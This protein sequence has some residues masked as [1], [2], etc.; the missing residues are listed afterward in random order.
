MTL[1]SNPYCC[2]INNCPKNHFKKSEKPKTLTV[3]KLDQECLYSNCIYYHPNRSIESC[4]LDCCNWYCKKL[5]RSFRPIYRRP[6]NN[7]FVTD[8]SLIENICS[9]L[10]FA[11]IHNL[12]QTCS[13]LPTLFPQNSKSWIERLNIQKQMYI[14]AKLFSNFYYWNPVEITS[15]E[16]QTTRLLVCSGHFHHSFYSP[17]DFLNNLV[18]IE[19]NVYPRWMTETI[20]LTK[21]SLGYREPY[22]KEGYCHAIDEFG[23]W[24]EAKI[25]NDVIQLRI[26][27]IIVSIPLK[28]NEARLACPSLHYIKNWKNQLQRSDKLYIVM[29]EIKYNAKIFDIREDRF[30]LLVDKCGICE[31][32]IVNKDSPLIKPYHI[33]YPNF[34]TDHYVLNPRYF[35]NSSKKTT[36]TKEVI[37]TIDKNSGNHSIEFVN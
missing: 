4:L 18:P 14:K 23:Y 5:H 22:T 16:L 26:G 27:K 25:E 21:Y 29:N 8:S 2:P 30:I 35:A 36:T 11:S 33:P 19:S 9:F 31:K 20:S 6:S 13:S 37:L 15:V 10:N 32:I 3:C 17:A 34:K 12:I 24:R 28:G 1:C 7:L